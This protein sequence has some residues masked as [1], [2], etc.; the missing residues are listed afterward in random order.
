[1]IFLSFK[2]LTQSLRKELVMKKC[3]TWKDK[4]SLSLKEN[5]TLNE[6]MRLRDCGKPKARELRNLAIEYCIRENIEYGS[7]SIPTEAIL[8]VTHRDID[9]Y[10]DK[11]MKEKEII[12]G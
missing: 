9:F 4:Y 8:E 3:I 1:M 11:M 2:S 6:I 12:G 5:L 7:K 10:F